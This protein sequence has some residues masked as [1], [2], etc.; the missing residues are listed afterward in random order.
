MDINEARVF[1]EK[2][3]LN[4][5]WAIAFMSSIVEMSPAG[6]LIPGGALVAILGFIAWG[7]PEILV[8]VIFLSTLGGFIGVMSAYFL[9]FKT[10]QTL[11]T[12]L[13][14]KKIARKADEILKVS[15]PI[16][17]TTSM[18]AGITRFWIAYIAGSQK[19]LFTKFLLYALVSSFT[20]SSALTVV[21]YIAGSSIEELE[22]GISIL[23][24]L[25]WLLIIFSAI[26]IIV[27]TK[28]DKDINP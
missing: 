6:W 21:G 10:G 5:W 7:N 13:N 14:Q 23:G 28:K 2:F 27:R 1:V 26:V 20:W 15:G 16:V 19:Y 17:L 3:F 11:I 12:K 24:I 9:G 18:L 4:W 25:T 22:D 8:G